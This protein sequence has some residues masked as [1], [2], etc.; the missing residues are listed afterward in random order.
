MEVNEIFDGPGWSTAM[1]RRSKKTPSS[2]EPAAGKVAPNNQPKGFRGS[3]KSQSTLHRVVTASRLPCLPKY[4]IRVIIRP[5]GGFDIARVDFVLL[6]KAVI[7]AAKITD[8]Q[9]REDT[10][11]PN[12]I[13]NTIVI[14]TPYHSNAAAR[15]PDPGRELGQ[16]RLPCSS[17][18]SRTTAPGPA[19]LKAHHEAQAESPEVRHSQSMLPI[20]EYERSNTKIGPSRRSLKVPG[21][22]SQER[23]RQR[24]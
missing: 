5:R 19:G 6:A 20:T 24:N 1:V 21:Q 10:I 2:E 4:Q 17:S 9:A 3:K 7:M 18:S 23:E 22:S 14:S 13:Q 15:A 8:E 11:C 16:Q 12:K